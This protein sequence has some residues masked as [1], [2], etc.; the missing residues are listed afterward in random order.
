M[1]LTEER[2]W[3][4]V[5]D[6]KVQDAVYCSAKEKS[7]PIYFWISKTFKISPWF[8]RDWN[9]V[10]FS[11]QKPLKSKFLFCIIN[12]I[13]KYSSILG[14]T[15]FVQGCLIIQSISLAESSWSQCSWGNQRSTVFIRIKYC[16]PGKYI[17]CVK[18]ASRLC[19][20]C[21][22]HGSRSVSPSLCLSLSCLSCCL[23]HHSYAR[24]R[25]CIWS[26]FAVESEV[27]SAF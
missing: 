8:M 14:W 7:R 15:G 17:Q 9:Q 4:K 24:S 3:K 2:V 25:V 19:F 22:I 10:K 6:E 13:W 11:R 5:S 20:Q 16:I 12:H 27:I 18:N 21:N 26:R 1:V 23:H